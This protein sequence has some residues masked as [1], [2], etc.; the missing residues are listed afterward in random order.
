[1]QRGRSLV[2]GAV[3]AALLSSVGLAV[4]TQLWTLPLHV[5]FQYARTQYDDQ[6]DATLDMM[7]IKNIKESGWFDSNPKLN[8]P[9]VQHWA[10]WPMGG[11]LL[12]YTIK[13]ALVD[14]TGDVPLTLNLFWLLTFPLTALVA[15]PALRSMR[16]SWSSSLVGAVLFSLTPYHFRN[17]AAHENLAFHVGVPVIVVLCVRVLGP[18]GA[19]PS[20]H[21]LR[22]WRGWWRLRWLMLGAV[23]VGV[24]GI[25]YLAF[26]L[27]LLLVCALISAVAHRRAFPVVFA[28]IL[29]GVGLAASF[30]ANWPTLWFRAHHPANLLGVPDRQRG[31]SETYPLRLV[32]LLSPVTGHRFGPFSALADLL[33]EPKREGMATANLGI[34]AAVG[35]VVALAVVLI[36]AIRAGDRRGWMLEA[37]IGVIVAAA[38]LLATKG[39][40]SRAL[41]LVGL[42][43][44]RAWNRIAIV[45]AF[46]GIVVFGRLLDRGRVALLRRHR[47]PAR[48]S[49]FTAVLVAVIV[50]GVLD[51]AS[52]VMMPDPPARQWR[53]DD[54]FVASLERRLPE[55]AMVFQLPVVDFPEHSATQ[56]M[57]AN[58]LIKEGYLH[59][60]TLRWSAGGVRGRD[61]EWQWPA[62]TLPMR[63]FLRGLLAIGFVAVT[64]DRL[65]F[66]DNGDATVK[67]LDALLGP[68]ISSEGDRLVAWDLRPAARRLIGEMSA[69]AER[70]L[71]R[72]YLDLPRLYLSSDAAPLTDRG[73]SHAVCAEARLQMVNPGT[74]TV[75]AHL[76]VTLDPEQTTVE[77]AQVT[78]NGRTLRIADSHDGTLIPIDVPVGISDG[79]VTLHTP[80]VRCNATTPNALPSVAASLQLAAP[81]VG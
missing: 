54:A 78:V 53:A 62:A 40:F 68:P 33:Y 6:Q 12:A 26:M 55:S 35:F 56:L 80:G 14:T 24:T 51:Q 16:V 47:T 64:V 70:A 65:G 76:L 9:F 49:A 32:E 8:A 4:V 57:A 45:I 71:A 41:E 15:F 20:R 29:G 1:M 19:L 17:G 11:D 77:S 34:A 61:G 59:S 5:P 46:A 30:V 10:E 50:I 43:G 66:E 79:R 52:P 63:A 48:R 37:R 31:V 3:L 75:A 60:K 18:E 69:R 38:F 44:V 21:D 39:G 36:R 25:Y 81:D 13:K 22:H 7:L 42:L 23:L 58:D 74:R 67:Q 28:A 2:A 73:D 27:S 72:Q